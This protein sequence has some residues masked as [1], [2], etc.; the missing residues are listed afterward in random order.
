MDR[1]PVGWVRLEISMNGTP[2]LFFNPSIGKVDIRF[3]TVRLFVPFVHQGTFQS[4]VSDIL[5]APRATIPPRC[6]KE[7]LI[8]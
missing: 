4:L 8:S 7:Y 3:L 1:S 6:I 5:E 2:R